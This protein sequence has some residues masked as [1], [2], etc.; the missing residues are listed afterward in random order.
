MRSTM[1][2]GLSLL[3]LA[4]CGAGARQQCLETGPA[5]TW[6]LIT[7]DGRGGT[8]NATVEFGR[9]SSRLVGTE[10]HAEGAGE[11]LN[12]PVGAIILA[13]DSLTFEFAPAQRRVRGVCGTADSL[14]VTVSPVIPDEGTPWYRGH[15]RRRAVP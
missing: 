8:L 13:P 14:A 1:L 11:P 9:D 3:A 2:A 7:S 10:V 15:L 6:E 12:Y 5:G 4:G